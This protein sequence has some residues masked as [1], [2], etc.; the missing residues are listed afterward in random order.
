MEIKSFHPQHLQALRRLYL[1]SRVATFTWLDTTAYE[2]LDFD[3]DSAGEEIWVALES[4]EV[5]GFI[6]IWEPDSFVHHLFVS[7]QWLKCG[8]G[9][10]LLNLAKQRYSELSLKCLTQNSNA[11]DFYRS[12]GFRVVE[13]VDNG[14]ESYHLMTFTAQT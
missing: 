11:T 3:R 9:L 5:I 1:E 4:G 7:P 14:R 12:Q 6:S 10:Q 8:V 2:L 13:T